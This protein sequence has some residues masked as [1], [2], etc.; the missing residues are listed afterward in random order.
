MIDSFLDGITGAALFG[1]LQRP[2][3][4]TVFFE[5]EVP[6][7]FSERSSLGLLPKPKRRTASFIFGAVITG[8]ILA[9]LFFAWKFDGTVNSNRYEEKVLILPTKPSPP[10]A[11]LLPQPKTG[12]SATA[13]SAQRSHLRASAPPEH[14]GRRSGVATNPGVIGP[15]TIAAI[16]NPHGSAGEPAV[17]PHRVP[18]STGVGNETKS[19]SAPVHFGQA[20]GVVPNPNARGPATVAAIGNEYGSMRK[21]AVVPHGV[22][23]STGIDN[24]TKSGSDARTVGKVEAIGI[25]GVS[26][27][28]TPSVPTGKVASGPTP[29]ATVAEPVSTNLVVLSKPDVQYTAEARQLRIQGDVILR[30]RFTSSGQVVV[31]GIVRGLGHGLDEEARQAAEGIRFRPAT[32]NGQPVDL[33]TNIITSFQLEH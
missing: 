25:P 8:G 13:M 19:E 1:K 22:V 18:G 6:N 24:G 14:P 7:L 27:D 32:R 28:T 33:T 30:A 23:G 21:P 11:I 2:G 29:A 20:F 3:A 15:A 12:L 5:A 16:G 31:L 10:S 17:A 4:P 26:S 9:L